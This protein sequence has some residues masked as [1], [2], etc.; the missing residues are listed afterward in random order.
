[1]AETGPLAEVPPVCRHL[2]GGDMDIYYMGLGSCL[3]NSYM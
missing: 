1:M 2:T 3:T